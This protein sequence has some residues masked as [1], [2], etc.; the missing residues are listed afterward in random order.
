[1]QETCDLHVWHEIN[2]NAHF[3]GYL[4][5]TQKGIQRRHWQP[6]PVLLPGNSQGQK[7]LLGCRLWGLTESD[8]IKAN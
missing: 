1:M 7:S 3:H 8:T 6:T 4:V 5:L 2:V